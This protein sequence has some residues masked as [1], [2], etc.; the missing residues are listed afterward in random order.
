MNWIKRL[1]Y[2]FKSNRFNSLYLRNFILI[3]LLILLPLLGM[4]ILVYFSVYSVTESYVSELSMNSLYRVRD[5]VD[6]TFKNVD[7]VSVK[8]SLDNRTRMFVLSQNSAD[9]LN[10]EFILQTRE[11]ISMYTDVYDYIDSIYV[12]SD[13]NQKIV[14]NKYGGVGNIKEGLDNDDWYEEYVK[15]GLDRW[16][17][18]RS[19][20]GYRPFVISLVRPIT[21]N[22]Q[23]KIGAVIANINTEK[24]GALIGQTGVRIDEN[25]FIVDSNG[26]ILYN[27][28]YYRITQNISSDPDLKELKL[29]GSSAI[30][31]IVNKDKNHILNAVRSSNG[32]DWY[33]SLVPIKV[34]KEN[35]DLLRSMFIFLLLLSSAAAV[36]VTF[37]ISFRTFKPIKDIISFIDHPDQVEAGGKSKSGAYEIQYIADKII[38]MVYSSKL[39]EQELAKR[40]TLL[41]RAQSLVLQNQITPHFLY[42]T[43]ENIN[44]KAIRLAGEDNDISRIVSNLSDMLHLVT[45]TKNRLIPISWE[46]EH[47][48]RFVE[49]MQ[50]RYEDKLE[51]RWDIDDKILDFLIP[52]LSLQPLIENAITHGLKLKRQRG[53]IIIRGSAEGNQ[54]FIEISDNGVGMSAE[55]LQFI[56]DELNRDESLEKSEHIGMFNVN[57]RI[58]L[59]FGQKYGLKVFSRENEGTVVR[60][61]LP[62]ILSAQ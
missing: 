23:N 34:F 7:K 35:F 50:I 42:N 18:V 20:N 31:K 10:S 61:T 14:S 21:L 28:D 25:I 32:S 56:N 8:I 54:V 3:L 46:I 58:R 13:I 19:M 41:N 2:C 62:A 44:W 1:L 40:I 43:L 22:R 27:S 51:V 9:S 16:M 52:K 29:D 53:T 59:I 39:L 17:M 30:Y 15:R 49:I 33:I 11:I 47:C 36:S 6:N 5:V 24:L 12:Y 55:K 57:L 4:G 38:K 37:I 60:I 45:D 26:T 48:R